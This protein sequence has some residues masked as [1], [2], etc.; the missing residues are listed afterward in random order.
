MSIQRIGLYVVALLAVISA[1]RA[2]TVIIL[3]LTAAQ[4]TFDFGSPPP[5]FNGIALP[6]SPNNYKYEPNPFAVG[7]VTY[8]DQSFGQLFV[9]GPG[10]SSGSFDIGTGHKLLEDTGGGDPTANINMTFA[11]PVTGIGLIA[12]DPFGAGGDT[13]LFNVTFG[14]GGGPPITG[15]GSD[16]SLPITGG[17]P[18]NY[19]AIFDIGNHGISQLNFS[20]TA[21]NPTL[22]TVVTVPEPNS[23]WLLM[24]L[25]L[26]LGIGSVIRKSMKTAAPL[27]LLAAFAIL[28]V[29]S[30]SFAQVNC[31]LA[32]PNNP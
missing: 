2:D 6:A 25:I 17:D 32:V 29:P 4:F 9:I 28:A 1:A 18:P 15:I 27:A 30:R 12:G 26:A 23:V 19:F 24:T 11:T 22:D 8:D 16:G 20:D 21:G 31:N 3:E 10:Y 5:T 13:A 7:S 14:S